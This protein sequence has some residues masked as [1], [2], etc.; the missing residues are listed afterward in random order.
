VNHELVSVAGRERRAAQ[1]LV[2]RVAVGP[3]HGHE[4]SRRDLAAELVIADVEVLQLHVHQ[5]LGH[6][7]ADP[8]VAQVQEPEMVREPGLRQVEQERRGGHR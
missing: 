2:V 6:S 8:V 3:V 4:P 7:A 1:A 5:R